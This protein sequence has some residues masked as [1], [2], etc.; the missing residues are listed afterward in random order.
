MFWESK[1][2][3]LSCWFEEIDLQTKEADTKDL[4]QLW[5]FEKQ[6]FQSETR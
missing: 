5:S 6:E 4:G 3:K 1:Q 2:K